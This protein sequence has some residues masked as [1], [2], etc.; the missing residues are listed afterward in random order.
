MVYNFILVLQFH[1]INCQVCAPLMQMPNLNQNN[2]T[3][4]YWMGVG[5][6]ISEAQPKHFCNITLNTITS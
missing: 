2:Y 5:R 4:I 6:M 1:E 3:T